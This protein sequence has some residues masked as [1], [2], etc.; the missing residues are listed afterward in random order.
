MRT[1]RTSF[2]AVKAVVAEHSA[3]EMPLEPDSARRH[4]TGI[5]GHMQRGSVGEL[6]GVGGTPGSVNQTSAS[7]ADLAAIRDA[8]A[9]A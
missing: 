3:P 8:Q 7:A 6:A 9:A 5:C 2:P 1:H 4:T